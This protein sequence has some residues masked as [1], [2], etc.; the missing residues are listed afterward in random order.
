[1]DLAFQVGL[2][3]E[4]S[5]LKYPNLFVCLPSTPNFQLAYFQFGHLCFH[6]AVL[7]ATFDE[8]SVKSIFLYPSFSVIE[9]G[10]SDS[11]KQ[12]LILLIIL[13]QGFIIKWKP[14]SEAIFIHGS[15]KKVSC[16]SVNRF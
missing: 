4:K 5:S 9:E 7:A 12:V 1:M 15:L 3:G 6:P 10:S 14:V 2:K 8:E 16:S 13:K 11:S